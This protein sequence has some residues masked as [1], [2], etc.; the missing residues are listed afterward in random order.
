MV[1]KKEHYR[2]ATKIT[3]SHSKITEALTKGFETTTSKDS[4]NVKADHNVDNFATD[5]SEQA[6]SQNNTSANEEELDH[7]DPPPEFYNDE[8]KYAHIVNPFA[9]PNFDFDKY[10]ST[11]TTTTTTTTTTTPKPVKINVET[12]LR[13]G[14][15]PG[16]ARP[17]LAVDNKIPDVQDDYFINNLQG[18]SV[19]VNVNNQYIVETKRFK[20]QSPVI[21]YPSQF[22]PS[23]K[24]EPSSTLKLPLQD[25]TIK[26]TDLYLPHQNTKIHNYVAN[27]R[28]GI[29][30]SNTP[31]YAEYTPT[32][33]PRTLVNEYYE[34]SNVRSN[35]VS[36]IHAPLKVI[37]NNTKPSLSEDYYY[38]YEDETPPSK[39]TLAVETS[40]IVTQYKPHHKNESDE[41]EYYYDEAVDYNDK[42]ATRKYNSPKIVVHPVTN[43]SAD[44]T[45][46]Q[47]INTETY[48]INT[49]PPFNFNGKKIAS[50]S[51]TRVPST[52]KLRPT[53]T[54]HR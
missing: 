22:I 16:S 12:Q 28:R 48:H 19:P 20:T 35:K 31:K 42:D 52:R 53:T 47:S 3:E 11:F 40:T 51:T 21:N 38:E 25:E 46:A 34:S 36:K 50:L 43:R 54:P 27:A 45:K 4:T 10:L 17:S 1:P 6:S 49:E 39:K 15:R 44:S 2:P 26:L 32:S 33:T 8:N 14:S 30:V 29:P 9:D 5:K 7:L 24:V 37:L 18:F 13:P 41:Y 23:R